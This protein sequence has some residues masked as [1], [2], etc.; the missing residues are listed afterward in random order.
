[1]SRKFTPHIELE[2]TA[3]SHAPADLIIRNEFDKF[4]DFRKDQRTKRTRILAYSVLFLTLIALFTVFAPR[5]YRLA[6]S[7]FDYYRSSQIE[8]TL[9]LFGYEIKASALNNHPLDNIYASY[10]FADDSAAGLP[11]LYAYLIHR[12]NTDYYGKTLKLSEVSEKR[13]YAMMR[14]GNF[15]RNDLCGL[16]RPFQ[17]D[18]SQTLRQWLLG[19]ALSHDRN[20]EY[21]N[22]R[23]A[24][25]C[26]ARDLYSKQL[27]QELSQPFDEHQIHTLR[28]LSVRE[29]IT[30]DNSQQVILGVLKFIHEDPGIL[31]HIYYL[32]DEI[33]RIK[34]EIDIRLGLM[35]L[36]MASEFGFR[37]N[38][39][40]Y[41][42]MMAD[43]AGG[44]MLKKNQPLEGRKALYDG[45]RDQ[46]KTYSDA[47]SDTRRLYSDINLDYFDYSI[48]NP[49]R[50]GL[51]VK[52]VGL[53]GVRRKTDGGTLYEHKGIDLMADRGTPVFP[54]REGYVVNVEKD[55]DGHG[56]YVVVW[57][58]NTLT[59]SYSHLDDD[60]TFEALLK[61]YTDEGAF[62]VGLQSR[63]GSVGTS[64]NIPRGDPQY[65][66]SHL[67]LEIKESSIYRNPFLMLA[68][69]IAV[70]H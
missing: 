34:N 12:C 60:K 10:S 30:P 16:D 1:M 52:D 50:I 5:L 21:F 61:Q 31:E 58:D 57:H 25:L 64:G 67:H 22:P 48:E 15:N 44:D 69:N 11:A 23:I 2:A 51:K 8:K 43:M 29:D 39:Q 28:R 27:K 37:G 7:R 32:K 42:W 59:S 38:Y 47:Y 70:I 55:A 41:G 14:L 17:G 36:A 20:A 9:G 63:I 6:V 18:D 40:V 3:Y 4:L 54:V 65:G 19:R 33:A 35:K 53:F 26:E 68:D 24:E 13:L 46:Y 45:L 49:I 56:N 62:W 66:Y